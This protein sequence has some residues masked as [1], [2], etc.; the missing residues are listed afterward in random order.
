MYVV[1]IIVSISYSFN[2]YNEMGSRLFTFYS[3]CI[4]AINRYLEIEREREGEKKKH[5]HIPAN[6]HN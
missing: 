3:Y 2:M 5:K 6:T 4:I 1:N